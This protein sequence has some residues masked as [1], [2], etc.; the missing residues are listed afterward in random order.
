MSHGYQSYLYRGEFPTE[1]L[2]PPLLLPEIWQC[3]KFGQLILVRNVEIVAT[4]RQILRLKCTKFHFGWGLHPKPHWGSLQR[5]PK[6]IA[7]FKGPTSKGREG[8][9][10]KGR[11]GRGRK[12][13]KGE[14]GKG[15]RGS[16]WLF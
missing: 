7:V 11:K 2:N 4:R 14:G 10:G 1:I 12:D 15:M 5:F 9:K 16:P 3:E 13:R 6:P 8:G